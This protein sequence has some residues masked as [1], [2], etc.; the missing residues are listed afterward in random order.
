MSTPRFLAGGLLL[1]LALAA[2]FDPSEPPKDRPAQEYDSIEELAV[3]LRPSDLCGRFE[4]DSRRVKVFEFGQ[5][6]PQ[7]ADRGSSDFVLISRFPSE[8]QYDKH[9]RWDSSGCGG[10]MIYGPNWNVGPLGFGEIP[11]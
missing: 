8:D 10:P 7:G 1:M 3:A 6:W 11:R 5:C 4:D 2:C 9:K